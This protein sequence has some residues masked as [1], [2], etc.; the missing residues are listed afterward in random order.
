MSLFF[1]R[2][3]VTPKIIFAP[4]GATLPDEET[5]LSV[6]K[7]PARVLGRGTKVLIVYPS[8]RA[9]LYTRNGNAVPD[10]DSAPE[11]EGGYFVLPGKQ[12]VSPTDGTNFGSILSIAYMSNVD[13]VNVGETTTPWVRVIGLVDYDPADPPDSPTYGILPLVPS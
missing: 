1:R 9:V 11:P 10:D 6:A 4:A 12:V 13:G 3:D 7:Y 8:D 5:F 2:R